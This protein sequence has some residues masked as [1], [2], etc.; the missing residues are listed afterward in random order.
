M[1]NNIILAF[2]DQ[3]KVLITYNF[4]RIFLVTVLQRGEAG[5]V[6]EA[7]FSREY[8]LFRRNRATH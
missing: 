2:I 4:I 7:R 3:S 8:V 1:V 6:F 5:G